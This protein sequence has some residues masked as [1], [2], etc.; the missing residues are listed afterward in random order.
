MLTT[1]RHPSSGRPMPTTIASGSFRRCSGRCRDASGVIE[2]AKRAVADVV[3]EAIDRGR[4]DRDDGPSG[5]TGG[6]SGNERLTAM[7]GLVLLLLLTV[8]AAT[9]IALGTFLP[10]HIALGLALLPPVALKLAT[11]G[12]RMIRYYAGGVAY[13]RRGPPTLILRI[14]APLLVLSTVALF[15]SG[16]TLIVTGSRAD[17]VGTVHVVSFVTWSALV[18]IH[19]LAYALRALR[20]GRLDFR[21][22]Q[23]HRP[24]G[25]WVREALVVAALS[26]GVVVAVALYP[27]DNVLL[28]FGRGDA[29]APAHVS[30]TVSSPH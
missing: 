8:E 23:G 20:K 30:R 26:A 21:R 13:V 25:G 4:S 15:G 6:A 28:R 17:F 29:A 5:R 7:I 2:T 1:A 24:P 12:W 16:V 18:I 9:A 22:D 11:T 14:L 10:V 3:L 19:V 27:N